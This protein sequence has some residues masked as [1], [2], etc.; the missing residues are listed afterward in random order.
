[1]KEIS[2]H[3]LDIAMNSIKADATLL[4]ILIEDSI[5]KNRLQISIKDNG[6]GMSEEVKNKVTDPFYTTRQTRKVG[7]GIPLL[8]AAC[9]RSNGYL[10]IESKLDEGTRI[11]CFFERDHIDR[12]PLGNMGDTIMTIINCQGNCEL[13]YTYR[14]DRGEFTLDTREVKNILHGVDIRDSK[15][16]LWINEYINENMMNLS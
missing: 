10:S 12:S 11:F 9:E 7:L 3:I 5:K 2:M 8:K 15:I 14:T 4:E 13:V 6:K 16:L 1:M